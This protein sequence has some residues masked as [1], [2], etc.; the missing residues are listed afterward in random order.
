MD[1]IEKSTK[2]YT[3][4]KNMSPS[5]LLEHERKLLSIRNRRAYIKRKYEQFLKNESESD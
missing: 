4:R 3:S 1:I 5:E 2:K